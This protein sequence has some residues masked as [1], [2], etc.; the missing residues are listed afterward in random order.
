MF[1]PDNE[2][3]LKLE[4]TRRVV[5]PGDILFGESR[6]ET[7]PGGCGAVLPKSERGAW[8][9][10]EAKNTPIFGVRAANSKYE[11]LLGAGVRVRS[12][13]APIFRVWGA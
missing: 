10:A 13:S 7:C 11:A 5:M 3:A 1:N 8:A 12:Q 4:E 9:E 2:L 6:T